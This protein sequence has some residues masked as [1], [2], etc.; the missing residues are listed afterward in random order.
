MKLFAGIGSRRTPP[1]ILELMSRLSR[2]LTGEGWTLRS[3][4]ARG[5]DLA[6]ERGAQNRSEIFLAKHCRPEWQAESQ[7]VMTPSHWQNCSPYARQLHGRNS[8]II[9]GTDLKTPVKFVCCWTPDAREVGG[10]AV[11]IRVALKHGIEVRNLAIP[12]VRERAEAWVP[13]NLYP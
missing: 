8:A 5:A 12:E 6:F 4:G 9:L 3:G 1:E 11:G 7:T 10:T 2:K 13:S